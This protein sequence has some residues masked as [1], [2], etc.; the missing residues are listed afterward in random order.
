MTDQRAGP[1]PIGASG[2]ASGDARPPGGL[3]AVAGG[4]IAAGVAGASMAL[5]RF[6]L[7]VRTIPERMME[8]ALLFVPLDVFEAGI[9]RF[10]FEAKRYALYSAIVVSFL[11]LAALGAVALRRRWSIRAVAAV[12]IALWL[13]TMVVIM[14]VT[15]AGLFGG[16]LI[17]GTPQVVFG[18]LSVALSYVIALALAGTFVGRAAG[19]N[20][21]PLSE[22][23]PLATSR[24]PILLLTGTALASLMAA[25]TTER[26]L[27]RTRLTRV[28][29]RDPQQPFPSGGIDPPNPHPNIAGTPQT[30]VESSLP[31]GAADSAGPPPPRQL[32]RDK[33]GATLPS[34]RRPGQLAP[35]ITS[36]T[37]FY[38]VT[39]NAAGD[40]M[41]RTEDWRLQIDGEVQRPI[42]VDYA[43][44]R[45]LP[46]V[47]ITKT[48]ECVS[49]FVAKCE[50]VPF[51]CDLISTARWKGARVSDVMAL[52]G[53]VK[54]G[55][56][57]LATFAADEYT[58]A[59]PIDVALAP[60]TLLVYEMNGQVLPRE[61]GYPLRMLVPGR[62]GMKSA[63]WIV[64]LRVLRREFFDWY[65]QRN[66]SKDG[67]VKTMSR[68]DLPAPGAA[69]P[70]GVHRIAGIAYAGDRGV[71]KVE[72]SADGGA[73]WQVA[74]FIEPPAGRD[75]WVRWQGNF[76]LAP[77]ADVTLVARTTDGTG[78]LQ[79][80]AFGL[81]QPDGGSGWHMI[82]VRVTPTATPT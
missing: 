56:G 3:A 77:G 51:G 72:Y 35:L 30:T 73:T 33:D 81:P 74:Q 67:V 26:W 1:P 17:N 22:P 5:L 4:L 52:A 40:P 79:T 14:P 47:E 58:T 48:L 18:Y 27:P 9:R 21:E 50:L 70:P 6:T 15:S 38:I 71:A 69:L 66:W 49:N 11:T 13:F 60:D 54:A 28:L 65:G 45:T 12:G 53:G 62:Y 63:K 68:I 24:R 10:G 20:R 16:A 31:P 32:A 57:T 78:A 7:Q 34:G 55:A 64:A 82:Q 80:E 44:L 41:L 8:W 39:K 25:W 29:V 36:N 37:D 46:A 61:H 2:G 42:E 59:L 19:A 75:C 43:S 76:T 23:G